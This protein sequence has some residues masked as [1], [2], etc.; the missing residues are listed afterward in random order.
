MLSAWVLGVS[1]AL[2]GMAV[3]PGQHAFGADAPQ[4]VRI[5]DRIIQ[6]H[7]WEA[8]PRDGEPAQQ[9]LQ[10]HDDL[11]AGVH[12]A[13][14]DLLFIGD[15]ITYQWQKQ[16]LPVW[17]SEYAARKAFA[18]GINGDTTQ[19]VLWR[20]DHGELD[21]LQP[22]A[23]VLLIGTNNVRH[24]PAADVVRGIQAV[25]AEIHRKMPHTRILVLALFPRSKAANAPLRQK[26]EAVNAILARA[27]LGPQASYLDIGRQFLQPDGTLPETVMADGLHP[28]AQGYALW[29]AAI[30]PRVDA[31]LK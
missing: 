15:S 29:A 31:L 12:A 4:A 21:G 5:A 16:G 6:P 9:W 26:V 7:P 28:T 20:I 2:S 10:Q 30:K 3:S 18:L 27:D 11:V 23:T 13:A 19:N 1:I 17:Q 22:R 24:A 25:V 14:P 8:A